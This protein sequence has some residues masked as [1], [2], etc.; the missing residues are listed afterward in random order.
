M[1]VLY[2]V[3]ALGSE[4]PIQ[5]D[6][7]GRLVAQGLQGP[8][9]PVGNQGPQGVTGPTGLQGPAGPTGAKGDKGDT[10]DT[11]PQG[12]AGPVGDGSL[13]VFKPADTSRASTTTTADDPHLLIV[14][15][16]NSV[17]FVEFRFFHTGV[18]TAGLKYDITSSA[19]V[20]VVNL[21]R[22][23]VATAGT[24]LTIGGGSSALPI[25]G[26]AV[27]GTNTGFGWVLTQGRIITAATAPTLQVKW[28]QNT[29]NAG[30]TVM[31][32]GSF[33]R[34]QRIGAAP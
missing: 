29:S 1:T 23:S 22:S 21:Q 14:L 7:D 3:T 8:P 30:A 9:G 15:E 31:L 6:D 28:A 11:G 4:V 5:V 13:N 10:G 34:A 18:S 17:Y 16:A 26:V 32:A 20:S 24:S 19:A 33:L 2:G 27:P 25:V 12:P